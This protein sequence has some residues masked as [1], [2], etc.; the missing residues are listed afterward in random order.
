M[1]VDIIGDSH[2]NNIQNNKFALDIE[3]VFWSKRGGGIEYLEQALQEISQDRS[4]NI[5]TD[6]V[7]IFIGGNDLDSPFVAVKKLAK[8]YSA[9]INNIAR[10]AGAVAVLKQWPRPGARQGLNYWTNAGYFEYLLPDMLVM[11]CWTWSWDRSMKFN[12]SFF[13]R[14]GVHCRPDQYKKVIR[15][16]TSA[17]LAALR[18]LRRGGLLPA[19]RH[20]P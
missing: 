20:L 7:V 1:R 18:Y 13:A 15:Y 16:L 5:S 2:L 10:V 11:H 6:A 3:L 4:R 14:D 17:V 12:H 8:R 19:R 9:S